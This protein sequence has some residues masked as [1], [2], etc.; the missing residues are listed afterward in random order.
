MLPETTDVEAEV[1]AERIRLGVEKMVV[2][3][4]IQRFELPQVS[5][6]RLYA[7]VKSVRQLISQADEALYN[8]KASGRNQ[9]SVYA[10]LI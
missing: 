4:M 10:I 9:I 7:D 2:E 8:S 1:F 5:A 6:W 3:W